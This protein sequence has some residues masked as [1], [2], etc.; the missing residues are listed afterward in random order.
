MTTRG[1]RVIALA[2]MA[3]C[4]ATLLSGCSVVEWVM[5][6]VSDGATASSASVGGDEDWGWL[7]VGDCVADDVT[8]ATLAPKATYAKCAGG[9]A[10][11]E[12]VATSSPDA[13]SS[14]QPKED[15]QDGVT[16]WC[17]KAFEDYLGIKANKSD[18]TIAWVDEKNNLG[19]VQC[20]A[21]SKEPLTGSLKG[22]KK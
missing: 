13:T 9:E 21:A 19:N 15:T 3:A 1:A 22:I 14:T 6:P 4:A 18:Y 11:A 7:E 2:A 8:T 5:S 10:R 17:Q 12:L 16:A 20:F